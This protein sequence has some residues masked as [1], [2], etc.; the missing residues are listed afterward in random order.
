MFENY[1][2][3]GQITLDEYVKKNLSYRTLYSGY[4]TISK[5]R[6]Y[7]EGI[8]DVWHWSDEEQPSIDGVYWCIYQF[9]GNPPHPGSY[10]AWAKDHWWYWDRWGKEWRNL[11]NFD[12]VIAWM[13]I[14]SIQLQN[15]RSLEERLT[16]KGIV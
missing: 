10:Y 3:D 5:K 1:E 8:Y 13:E 4:F 14:P 7:E 9:D 6:A 12:V 11:P 16:M 15:D 2:C